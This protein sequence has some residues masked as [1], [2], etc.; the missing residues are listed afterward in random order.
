MNRLGM[1]VDL[2]HVSPA[3]MKDAIAASRA[4][5]IF[6]H[7]DVAALNPHPRNVPDDV[8]RLLPANGGVVMVTF[9]PAS[10]RRE[11]GRWGRERSAE[12]ARLKSLYS[13]QQ[14][15]GRR[16]ALKAWEAAHPRAA[17]HRSP[18]SPTISSMSPG[19]RA[20]TMSASAAIS[21]ASPY[22]VVGLDGVEDYPV[23]VRR[24]DPPRLER[25][26]PRQARRRQCPARAAPGRSGRRVDEG[27]AAVAWRPWSRRNERTAASRRDHPGHPAAAELH[28][29][30]GAPRRCA[31]RSSIRAATCP[32]SRPRPPDRRDD[33]EDP[34][35]PRP[36]RPLRLGRHLR[37]GARRCRSR[38]RTRTISSGSRGWPRTARATASRASR[39]SPTAGWSTATRST[40]GELTFDVRH[41]PGHTPGH[42][43]FHHPRI[44]ARDGRRRAVPGLD[45]PHR[46]SRAAT[47]SSCSIR[48][49]SGCGRWA[50]TPLSSPATGRCR[51]SP[52]NARPTRS[53]AT[54]AARRRPERLRL[55]SRI[56][57]IG[58]RRSRRSGRRRGTFPLETLASESRRNFF[59]QFDKQVPQWPS[60][61][62]KLRRRS[63][64]C[65]AAIMR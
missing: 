20:T 29:C 3:T 15:S 19:S 53:S 65:A 50:A 56:C 63:A 40:V 24:A 64:T 12:E 26:Q 21:T 16:P 34:A 28:A 23:P 47:T 9:V 37:R 43:V 42:V 18:P 60:P 59:G 57:A 4:P 36:Y 13:V 48:S 45:R 61:R 14:G 44:E 38:A 8:L 41:C 35:H 52:T 39:S 58:R 30:C 32:S 10:C 2:S 5:V 62:E 22:T 55:R 17:G 25:R 6:S 46:L 1:L 31:A 33:R 27:R 54:R 7:S 49:P 51:P 11:A